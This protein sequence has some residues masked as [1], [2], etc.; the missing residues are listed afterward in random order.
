ENLFMTP[1]VAIDITA[2]DKTDAGVKKAEANLGKAGAH[3]KKAAEGGFSK[4]AHLVKDLGGLSKIEF[5]A[6]GLA[7]TVEI[8]KRASEGIG[9][10]GKSAAK[11]GAET[12]AA[13]EGAEAGLSGMAGAA[14]AAAAAVV[15][16]GVATYALGEKWAKTGA[17]VARNAKTFGVTA[18]FLQEARAANERF[19]VSTDQTDAALDGFTST[20]YDARYGANNLVLGAMRQL[21]VQMK[22]GKDGAIDY[23]DA[24]NQVSDAIARQK[25]PAVQRRLASI[26]GLSSALPA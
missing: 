10:F 19:G 16:V 5:G 14:A 26:F 15:G 3:A 7:R 9:S 21:N 25:D 4:L 13:A 8:S 24:Y 2:R 22:I 11:A 1:Q 17:S 6:E 23:A 12:S 20:L 18:D